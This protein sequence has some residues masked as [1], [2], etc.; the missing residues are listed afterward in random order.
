LFGAEG[1]IVIDGD[2]K[3]FKSLFS[4]V[5]RED[6]HENVSKKIVDKTNS[7]LENLGYK[8]QVY[9][10]EV[11]FFYLADGLRSR[12]ERSG[13]QFNVV[14]TDLSFSTEQIKQL[15]SNEPEKFSP[16]V[17]LRP[18]YQEY[19]LPNL[20][21][22][23]GP[24]EVI[25]WLQLK[26]VF[27]HFQTTFPMLMPRNFGMVMDAETARK[28]AKTGLEIAEIFEDD[29]VVPVLSRIAVDG[30]EGKRAINSLEKIE[31]KIFRA[32]K[33]LHGDKLRQ[34]EAVKDI[35]FPNGSLQER[36]EN[37]LNFYQRDPEF[38]KHLLLTFDP[39]D[40][41]FNILSY[42]V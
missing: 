39:F 2:C 19:V 14:D 34:I 13:D 3:A 6:I 20:A 35:L 32:E 24:A 41:R 33:R 29:P 27:Q 42:T 18:V 9:C 23:G 30:A 10:R 22:V 28:F 31:R 21:Y 16:N 8:V 25:Y 15:I 7:S 5:I 4:N 40:F 11:N 1:L 38:I 12:I 36:T 37:F 17:I 26:E